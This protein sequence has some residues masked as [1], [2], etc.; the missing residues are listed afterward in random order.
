MIAC[1]STVKKGAMPQFTIQVF[2]SLQ[3]SNIDS[4]I[5]LPESK[6]I[7]LDGVNGIDLNIYSLTSTTKSKKRVASEISTT[8]IKKNIDEVWFCDE[9]YTSL[10]IAK[11]ISGKIKYKF[12]VH[13][14]KPHIYSFKLKRSLRLT[15]FALR[16]KK[17]FE[18]ADSIVLMSNSSKDKF[19]KYYPKCANKLQV[20]LLGAHIPQID[21]VK[22][23]EIQCVDD[24][25][26]FFGTIE[27][28]KN[29]YGLLKA[30]KDYEGSRK[31]VVAGNGIFSEEEKELIKKEKDKV[32]T[33]NRF[34]KD[35]ELVYLFEHARCVVLPYIEASQSGVLSMSYHFSTPVIVSNLPG[36]TEFVDDRSN[37]YIYKQNNELLDALNYM[38]SCTDYE[39]MR[40]MAHKYSED[41][42]DFNKNIKNIV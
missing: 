41:K 17:I 18:K 14:A 12:F 11:N 40:E 6:D 2:K 10:S 20:L 4:C 19:S 22:P 42:L 29:V 1:I 13:D 27:K 21:G 38:D 3:N 25:Y 16:R 9:T 7:S 32:V 5:F 30:F 23:K 26:L 15:Y 34:I 24:Y 35:E 36:L 33:I 28:Y 31:L 37:G 8:L 39:Q